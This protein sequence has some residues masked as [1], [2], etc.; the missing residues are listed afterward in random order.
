LVSCSTTVCLSAI[1]SIPEPSLL[2]VAAAMPDLL[3]ANICCS[4][5]ESQERMREG[6][7]MRMCSLAGNT[8][9]LCGIGAGCDVD[10]RGILCPDV[11]SVVCHG[12]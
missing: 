8:N 10:D 7:V 4:P 5:L 3:L 1:A 12:A 9:R 6:V 2:S 11:I